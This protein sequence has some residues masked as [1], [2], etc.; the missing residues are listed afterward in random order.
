MHLLLL[1]RHPPAPTLFP[2]TTL[3]RSEITPRSAANRFHVTPEHPVLTIR[4]ARVSRGDRGPGRWAD[5]D[6]RRLES[7]EPRFVPAGER[8]PGD[9][10]VFP[11][12]KGQPDDPSRPD[13]F[14][15]PLA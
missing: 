9:P 6:P 2:Y 12:N 3:F 8:V 15:R 10:P 11:L 4:R 5:I 13:D 1:L 7:A 14:L